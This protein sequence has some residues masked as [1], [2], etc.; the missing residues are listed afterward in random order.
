MYTEAYG[1]YDVN[2]SYQ[3]TDQLNVFVEGINVTDEIQRLHERAQNQA[4]YVTQTGARYMIGARYN[5]GK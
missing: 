4:F 2:V 3:V 1:Q 5:F